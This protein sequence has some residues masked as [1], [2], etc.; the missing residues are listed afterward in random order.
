MACGFLALGLAQGA[1]ASELAVTSSLQP[2]PRPSINP[3]ITKVAAHM[4]D[5]N[6]AAFHQWISAFR[7]RALAAGISPRTF[8]AAFRGVQLNPD[9]V[10]RDRNQSEFTKTIWD[11]LD[12]AASDQRV[13]DGQAAMRKYSHVLD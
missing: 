3:M 1:M 7:H 12:S 6:D 4:P 8:E 10:A 9:V 13:A 5:A 2:A 11:Y